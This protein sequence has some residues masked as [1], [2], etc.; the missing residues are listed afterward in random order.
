MRSRQ[1]IIKEIFWISLLM[2]GSLYMSSV[3]VLA[4]ADKV[5]E[6]QAGEQL[7]LPDKGEIEIVNPSVA[8][9]ANGGNIQALTEGET[10]IVVRYR[11]KVTKKNEGND[12]TGSPDTEKPTDHPT[13]GETTNGGAATKG[14]T[15]ESSTDKPVTEKPVTDEPDT[16]KSA[17]DKPITDGSAIDKTDTDK[18]AADEPATDK[19][20]TE[21]PGVVESDQENKKQESEGMITVEYPDREFPVITMENLS[22]LSA[23]KSPVAPVILIE[24][25]NLDEKGIRLQLVG[26]RTG[27]QKAEYR[28]E[29]ISGGIRLL[30]GTVAEDDSY[31]L[32]CEAADKYGNKTAQR[33]V[34]TVNQGG[35]FFTYGRESR[36]QSGLFTPQIGLEDVDAVEI[37]ACMVNGEAVSCQWEEGKIKIPKENLKKGKNRISLSVRDAA[38]N[39]TDMEPWDF[40]LEEE[41]QDELTEEN[42]VKDGQEE[43]RA[44][45]SAPLGMIFLLIGGILVFWERK[46]CYNG[47]RDK[48]SVRKGRKYGKIGTQISGAS[49][50]LVP[51]NRKGFYRDYQP[52]VYSEPAKRN[53]A[54]SHRYPRGVRG[55][56]PR[57]KEWFR[58]CA[59]KDK[60]GIRPHSQR[61][62]QAFSG[63][64][65][66]LS[67][68][69]DGAGKKDRGKHGGLV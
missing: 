51:H 63:D 28:T 53:R 41:N 30:L 40:I 39:I 13:S 49:F 3:G 20:V 42:Q 27:E 37:L 65:D 6:L 64:A 44:G 8:R 2:L 47:S 69:K 1:R 12:F 35:T 31:I 23:N 66:L 67:E 54:L 18:P 46:M 5:L 59:Q 34:F 22:K 38:G 25:A 14:P 56:F 4:A 10:E 29:K 45:K 21:V 24:D 55:I 17:T 52:A 26:E 32:E 68:R 43:Y 19:P 15:N 60:R 62:G 16:D 57:V 48:I 11:I 58:V 33:W 7:L 50:R 61:A 36:I 9:P